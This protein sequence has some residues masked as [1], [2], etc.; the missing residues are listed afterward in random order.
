MAEFVIW[1]LLALGALMLASVVVGAVT[2]FVAGLF[3][4]L[5]NR[6]DDRVAQGVAEGVALGVAIGIAVEQVVADYLESV[7]DDELYAIEAMLAKGELETTLNGEPLTFAT[8]GEALKR[9][10]Y[11]REEPMA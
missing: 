9:R 10:Y 6:R 5:P 3:D 2:G 8:E 4:E 1:C 11:L 7:A